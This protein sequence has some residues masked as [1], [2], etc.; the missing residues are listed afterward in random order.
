MRYTTEVIINGEHTII[1]KLEP[2]QIEAVIQY[3][4]QL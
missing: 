4:E 3:I 1:K 2:G